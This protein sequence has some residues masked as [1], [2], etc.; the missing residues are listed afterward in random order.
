MWVYLGCLKVII[1][2]NSVH[3]RNIFLL[4]LFTTVTLYVLNLRL[5]FN[6]DRFNPIEKSSWLALVIF[7]LIRGVY[8]RFVIFYILY[9][10][11]L[12]HIM[13]LGVSHSLYS[14]SVVFF[15]FTQIPIFF[16]L[17]ASRFRRQELENILLIFSLVPI[18][19][20]FVGLLYSF[21]GF[22]DLF[23]IEYSTGIARLKGSTSSAYLASWCIAAVYAS[24]K[25]L[26]YNKGVYHLFIVLVNLFILY[27]TVARVP[28][29]IC[30][31]LS[32]YVFISS[33]HFAQ[34][35]KI[36]FCMFSILILS[37]VFLLFSDNYLSRVG[38]SGG[39]GR[40]II[41][42]YLLGEYA[43]HF[44]DWGAGFGHQY[45][46]MPEDIS[47]RT[48]TV[49]AHNEYIRILLE[50][51]FWGSILFWLGFVLFFVGLYVKSLSASK[52][53][54][55]LALLLFL[56]FSYF[57]NTITSPAVFSFIFLVCIVNN[58]E[59]LLFNRR[60]QIV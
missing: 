25:L 26:E 18:Y 60:Y 24:V 20:A 28:L 44:S 57:D 41:W 38:G 50:L 39:S 51:G 1:Q 11:L 17:C 54:I 6:I 52:N 42:D 48:S 46:L 21:L 37:F 5:V 4:L 19:V 12:I 8:N 7:I 43:L 10:I 36:L 3:M 30:M 9:F 45:I 55:I 16:I 31:V 59:G 29:F 49:A 13:L 35:L 53:E 56:L 14:Y 33:P 40:E 27:L 32:C 22:A 58:S 34:K 2:R 47:A 23:G 15:S